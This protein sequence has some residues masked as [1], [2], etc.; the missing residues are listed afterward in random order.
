MQS[1]RPLLNVRFVNNSDLL[2][3]G[4]WFTHSD[5]LCGRDEAVASTGRP[6]R[7]PVSEFN[8]GGRIGPISN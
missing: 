5:G 1:I 3:S 8:P 7:E 4:L 6:S 2:M